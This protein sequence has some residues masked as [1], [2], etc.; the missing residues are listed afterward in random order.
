MEK[1]V[2]FRTQ[3]RTLVLVTHDT[4]TVREFCDRAVWI[5][6]GVVR[7]D[8]DPADVVDEYTETMLGAETSA[9]AES[10]RRGDG[11]IQVSHVELLVGGVPV[12]RFRNGDDVTFRLHY[13]A[14]EAVPKPVFAVTIANV[15]GAIVTSPSTRD[16]GQVPD[17]L[18]GTGYVDVR[19]DAIPLIASQYVI[20]TEITGWARQHV[21]DH[22]QNALSFDVIAGASKEIHGL[23]TLQPTWS[24]AAD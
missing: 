19:F 13:S 16:V 15:G 3:G 21:H 2:D 18:H 8:G 11:H 6:H 14:P 20:H 5:D 17:S 4:N 9:G 24:Q 23:V 22:L 1:F 12:D 10:S 7:L